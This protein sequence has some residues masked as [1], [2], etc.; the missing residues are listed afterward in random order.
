MTSIRDDTA[1]EC[2]FA[3]RKCGRKESVDGKKSLVWGMHKV[4]S[5]SF[6]AWELPVLRYLIGRHPETRG[7]R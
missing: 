5:G 4:G 2:G 3:R 7:A 1:G 6:L